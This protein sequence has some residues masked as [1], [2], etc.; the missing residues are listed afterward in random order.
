MRGG[1][2]PGTVYKITPNE[3]KDYKTEN[4][5]LHDVQILDVIK[6]ANLIGFYP[7][8][9]IIGIEPYEISY[10]LELSNKISKE[11]KRIVNS[12]RDL[13]NEIILG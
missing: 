2:K 12:T 5:S 9:T 8:V 6:Q 10:S 3:L 7:E 11:F 13:I 4:L 1:H